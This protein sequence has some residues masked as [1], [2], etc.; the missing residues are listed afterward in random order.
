[1][2]LP[3]DPSRPGRTWTPELERY[4]TE[5]GSAFAARV[6]AMPPP[7]E[8]SSVRVRACAQPP[9]ARSPVPDT[10]TRNPAAGERGKASRIDARP[11]QTLM[12]GVTRRVTRT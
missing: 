1:M 6:P 9:A 11:S 12:P 5:V 7:P 10:V 4:W 3:L 8:L 2:Q